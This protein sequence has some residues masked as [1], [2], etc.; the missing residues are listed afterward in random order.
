MLPERWRGSRRTR[1]SPADGSLL[2]R[3]EVGWFAEA[4]QR[5]A[6]K[7]GL[8][9]CARMPWLELVTIL[10]AGIGAG[11]IN[12]IV[13]SGSLITFPTLLFFGYP[14]LVANMSNNIGVLPGGVSAVWGYRRELRGQ[15]ALLGRLVP[16]SA[17]GGVSGALLLLVLPSTVFATVVPVLIA[18]GLLLVILGPRLQRAAAARHPTGGRAPLHVRVLLFLGILLTGVYGGYFGAAQGVILM[19]LMSALLTQSLQTIN[20]IKNVLG[21]TANLAATGVFISLRWNQIDWRA[22]LLIGTGSF[23]GG[24]LGSGLGRRLHPAILRAIIVVV[25]TAAI[26]R[27]IVWA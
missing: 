10:L 3:R 22:A 9:Y 4:F 24:L 13:G 1:G 6:P 17:L 21:S 15:G 23:L 26:L 2:G 8:L 25:G 11:T 18:F 7:V 16:L 20:G 12:A 5:P 27:L 19:G 14:P